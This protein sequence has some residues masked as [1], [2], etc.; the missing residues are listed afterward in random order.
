MA[1]VWRALSQA[2]FA[3]LFFV[4][5]ASGRIQLWMGIFL[6]SVVLAAFFGRFYC[7]WICPVNTLMNLVT[8]VKRRLR[9]KDLAVPESVKKPV[10]R[11]AAL[12][13]FISYVCIRN[14]KWQK[15][16]I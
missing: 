3:V 6:L 5:V 13:A 10:Y 9:I 12:L 1:R 4:L 2:F 7:G 8:R 15:L 14:V 11:Y 16:F